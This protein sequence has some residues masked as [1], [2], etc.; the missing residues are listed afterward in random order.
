[1]YK[2]QAKQKVRDHMTCVDVH[3]SY[4]SHDCY[5]NVR[6]KQHNVGRANF[7][8]Q[9]KKAQSIMSEKAWQKGYVTVHI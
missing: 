2:K 7:V 4:F 8:L 5:K 1:M 3:S 9:F 6:Q